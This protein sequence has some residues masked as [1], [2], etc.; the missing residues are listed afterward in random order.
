MRNL[1]IPD[2]DTGNLDKDNGDLREDTGDM[3]VDGGPLED[4]TVLQNHDR[5]T[6]NKASKQ[7]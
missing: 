2:K 6:V 1:A 3:A 4:I 5:L 7:H